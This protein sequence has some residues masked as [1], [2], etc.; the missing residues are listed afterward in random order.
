MV[1]KKILKGDVSRD[2]KDSA[3]M[4]LT[5]CADDYNSWAETDESRKAIEN[6]DR[7]FII[8]EGTLRNDS[9]IVGDLC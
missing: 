1:G 4:V 9:G 5:D 2:V 3:A 7:D 6:L 8:A